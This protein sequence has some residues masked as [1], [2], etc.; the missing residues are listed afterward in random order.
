MKFS[1][2]LLVAF[3][4]GLA[5]AVVIS[6]FA[7]FALAT[8]GFHFPF[9]RIF[10]RTMM[11]MMLAVIIVLARPL[12]VRSLLADGFR[13][14]ASRWPEIVRGLILALI[15][16]AILFACAIGSGAHGGANLERLHRLPSFLLQAAAVAIIEEGFFRAFLQGGLTIDISRRGAL[17]LSSAIYSLSHLIRSPARFYVIGFHPMAG[18]HNLAGSTTQLSHPSTAIPALIGLFLLGLVLGEAFIVSESVY[19][20]LGLHAGFVLGMK[21]WPALLTP[22]GVSPPWWIAGVGRFPLISA[23]ASWIAAIV[24][25]AI[26]PKLARRERP[27]KSTFQPVNP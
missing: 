13:D 12:R 20:P 16:M 10:D 17:V 27:Q 19:L 21:S 22:G 18:L 9:P 1:Y 3:A 2:A 4:L 15:V 14:L 7:A 5:G 6:P 25:L 8:A 24:V 26:L 23:P 11:L